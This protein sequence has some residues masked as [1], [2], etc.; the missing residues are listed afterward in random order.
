M[1]VVRKTIQWSI[2]GV[3]YKITNVPYGVH[4]WGEFL[5]LDTS[6]K[7]TAIRDLMFMNEIAHELDYRTVEDVE[8]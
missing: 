5:D 6:I 7:V 3:T 4:D 8:F 1:V 2:N